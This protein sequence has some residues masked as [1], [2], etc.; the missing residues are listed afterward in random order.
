MR[1]HVSTVRPSDDTGLFAHTH[2]HMPPTLPSVSNQA[3][4]SQSSTRQRRRDRATARLLSCWGSR[5]APPVAVR[6]AERCVACARALLSTLQCPP[7]LLLLLL[8]RMM[9]SPAPCGGVLPR[10]KDSLRCRA[11][12]TTVSR[13]PRREAGSW[14]PYLYIRQRGGGARRASVHSNVTRRVGE[15]SLRRPP[16]AICRGDGWAVRR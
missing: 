13:R 3:R 5:A 8:P 6:D 15:R 7:P 4:T 2:A 16:R 14:R 9:S 11:H 1:W 12:H 10:R